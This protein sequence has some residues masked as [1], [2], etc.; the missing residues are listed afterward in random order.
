M[1]R[2][3]A[4]LAASA[5]ATLGVLAASPT[6]AFATPPA[7]DCDSGAGRYV[8]LASTT[9]ST[10]WSISITQSGFTNSFT[11]TTPGPSISAG[12]SAHS[13]IHIASTG[14]Y[15]GTT[16][17]SGTTSILCNTGPWR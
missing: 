6:A 3:A 10:L 14:T 4:I 1:R 9:G 15:Q 2:T 12:C 13:V 11:V 8:C 16:Q 17:T 7:P 5:L